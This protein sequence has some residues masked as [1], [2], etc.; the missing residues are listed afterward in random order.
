MLKKICSLFLILVSFVL[1]FASGCSSTLGFAPPK[2]KQDFNCTAQIQ[3]KNMEIKAD[4]SRLKEGVT[5]ITVNS[6]DTIK[7][8]KY[9]WV[10]S[11]LTVTCEDLDCNTQEGYLPQANFAQV[12]YSVLNSTAD[13][14]ACVFKEKKDNVCVYTGSCSSG[15][16]TLKE[17]SSTGEIK[18]FTVSSIGITV[19]FLEYKSSQII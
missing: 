14:N 17:D 7:G 3:Y 6:P 12:I 8:L 2:I 13:E 1:V 4:V 19:N 10:D 5:T 11:K 16:Y 18:E 15:A 9:K